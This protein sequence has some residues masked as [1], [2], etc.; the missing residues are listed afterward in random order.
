ML[1]IAYLQHQVKQ[2][3]AAIA[4]SVQSGTLTQD[5]SQELTNRTQIIINVEINNRQNN[6]MDLNAGQ[7]QELRQ[8]ADDNNRYINYRTHH[9]MGDWSGDKYNRWD[10]QH[11]RYAI[12]APSPT[13]AQPTL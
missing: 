1:Y 4:A 12:S 10:D 7:I 11:Q 3:Q 5:Q 6:R 13:R 9:P 8:M 2:Q